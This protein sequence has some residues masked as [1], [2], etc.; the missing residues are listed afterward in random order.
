MNGVILI[1][2]WKCIKYF[3][4]RF[5]TSWTY[6]R[7][8]PVHLP[9]WGAW[10]GR[11]GWQRRPSTSSGCRSASAGTASSPQ[12]EAHGAL[13]Y[14]MYKKS[15]PIF[16]VFLIDTNEQDILDIPQI[17]FFFIYLVLLNLFF[18]IVNWIF[19]T[20]DFENIAILI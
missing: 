13:K 11:W 6:S 18:A 14:S 10:R 12:N 17:V 16:I 9:G 5:T 2:W 8:V 3:F 19:V 15:C 20:K 4:W 7:I 1:F